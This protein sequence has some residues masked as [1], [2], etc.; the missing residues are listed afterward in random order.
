MAK[1]THPDTAK[2]YK[3]VTRN[4]KRPGTMAWEKWKKY[5]NG[6]T[7]RQYLN[8]GGKRS[9]LRWDEERGLIQIQ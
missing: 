3:V 4:P 5:R 8:R 6:M 1:A 7:V 9:T 2:I